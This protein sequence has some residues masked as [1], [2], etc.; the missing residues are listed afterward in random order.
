MFSLSNI[1]IS[2]L[3]SHDA[4][5]ALIYLKL[6][7]KETSFLTFGIDD[8]DMSEKRAVAFYESLQDPRSGHIIKGV[9]KN[10]IISIADIQR[11]EKKRLSHCGELSISALKLYWGTGVSSKMFNSLLKWAQDEGLKLSLIHISEP[12]RPY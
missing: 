5:D 4:K 8:L 3:L 12:T 9:Y 2:P 10:K 6:I 1:T 11:P 7:A